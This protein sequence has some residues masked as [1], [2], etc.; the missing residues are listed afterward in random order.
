M[1]WAFHDQTTLGIVEVLDL[2][3]QEDCAA[4][5]VWPLEARNAVEAGLRGRPDS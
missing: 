1:A 4:P 3:A 5:S 2:A